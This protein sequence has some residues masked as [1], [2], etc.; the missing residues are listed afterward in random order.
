MAPAL[1]GLTLCAP[2]SAQT[3]KLR[4]LVGEW[5]LSTKAHPN[6][7]RLV[8]FAVHRGQLTGTYSDEFGH[9]LPIT[10]IAFAKGKYSFRVLDEDLIFKDLKFAGNNLEGIVE[11]T[12]SS[13]PSRRSRV[14]NLVQMVRTSTR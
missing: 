12:P 13:R 8:T 11:P 1:C 14:S 9:K 3:S 5:L 2:T 10:A 7:T 4:K 6:D